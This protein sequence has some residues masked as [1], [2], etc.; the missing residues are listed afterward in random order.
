MVVYEIQKYATIYLRH[1]SNSGMNYK[2]IP[3]CGAAIEIQCRAK[4]ILAES[5]I[6]L[7]YHVGKEKIILDFMPDANIRIPDY[8]SHLFC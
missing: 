7:P 3:S 1:P 4:T 6:V 2:Y 5:L 8:P